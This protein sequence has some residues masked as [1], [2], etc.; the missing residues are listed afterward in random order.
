IPIV[1]GV[2]HESDFTIADFAADLRAPTPT[3]AA[4]AAAPDCAAIGAALRHQ[5]QRLVRA[6]R[7]AQQ[8]REQ[9]L[10]LA[11]RLLRPP[12]AQWAA[13]AAR[14]E[15]LARRLAGSHALVLQR[16]CGRAALL[17][18]RLRPPALVQHAQRVQALSRSLAQALQR[19]LETAGVRLQANAAALELVSPQAVLDRGYAIVSDRSGVVVRSAGALAPGQAVA[20]RVAR[21]GFDARVETIAADSDSASSA[22]APLSG[23]SPLA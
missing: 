22:G 13:R 1:C 18:R 12:S 15:H 10:D 21:G 19:R 9:R 16:R 14:L 11:V 2:G 6:A 3:A 20:V 5:A 8:Q 4:A 17:A 7:R 23:A